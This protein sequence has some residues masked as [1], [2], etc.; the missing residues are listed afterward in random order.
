V[1][2]TCHHDCPDSCGWVATVD[3]GRVV[4]LRGDPSHP[5]SQGELCPKVN[6]FVDRVYADDRVLYPLI[7]T[8]PKGAGV[9]RR[10][11]WDEA[12]ALV[13][14]RVGH[15]VDRLGGE[16]V[17]PWWDAGTQ[18]LIQMSCLDRPFFA[19]LGASRSTGSVC[20][21]AAGAGFSETYGS[22]RGADPSDLR[23][24][25][26]VILWATN[27]RLTNRHLWPAVEAARA[28]GA[29]IV[30]IDP[31]RTITADAADWFVQPRPG[32][33]T[34]LVLAMLHVLVR[35]DLVDHDY[36]ERH[37]DG[38]TEL[39][40]HVAD[41]TP[42]RAGAVTGLD[43]TEIEHLARCYGEAEPAFIRTLIGAEH[44]EHG[45]RFFRA[46]GCLPL[47]TGSWRHVGGGLARSVG[48][49][50]QTAVDDSVFDAPSATR[51]FNMAQLGRTLTEPPPDGGPPV[52]ALF[53]WCGNPAVSLPN[54]GAVRR[55]LARD[56]LFCVVSEQFLTDTARYAD[57]VFPATTQLEQLDVVAS[58]GHLYLGWNEPAV[59][60]LGEAVPNTELWRRLAGA[61]GV[62]DPRFALDDEALVRA[63]LVGVDVDE[64]RRVGHVRLPVDD[65]LL[66]YA[67]GGFATPS[68]RARLWA[69]P[70]GDS[71][72][73][74]PD[75]LD[76]VESAT[77]DAGLSARFPLAL[78][79][80]KTHTRFLNTT[81]SNHH[82]HLEAGRSGG[83]S[84]SRSGGPLGPW[85]SRSE[86]PLG[87]WV[88]R[89][90]GPLGPWVE[91][92]PADASA[93]GIVDGA[94]VRIRNDR[95]R[96]DLPA[97]ISDRLRPGVVAVPW[98]WWG[99]ENTVN[100]LTNDRQTDWGGGVAYSDTLVEVEPV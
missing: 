94:I 74:V 13:A 86:G 63:A 23:H 40:A 46:L 64:L 42:E 14:E 2:G 82:G 89:S 9:F 76:A 60:P 3:G 100:V 44:H 77:G 18:G 11:S 68:G 72:N 95:G 61:M 73:R 57:V 30:V 85:V 1:L 99:A 24:A 28:N 62:N 83:P 12:L 97:R 70:S 59:E 26:F 8:G 69:G 41:W 84:A 55:G 79:T 16:A 96:L 49:W 75:H 93:R 15:V 17:L 54:A 45:A 90:G 29:Q 10:A 32:T 27:T 35:D 92:D 71:R 80:P 36:V 56:D 81:Y 38:F 5:F 87:P 7:R 52:A 98:G 4:Q 50:A 43:P 22:G 65:P 37:T 31:I 25:R 19:G 67:E 33:D 48:A 47:V 39:A 21:L 78:L 51:S 53:A 34:A 91:L 66:P 20:G 6:R 58:W 88:S